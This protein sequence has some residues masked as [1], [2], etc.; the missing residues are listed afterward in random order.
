[1]SGDGRAH[2]YVRRGSDPAPVIDA[3]APDNVGRRQAHHHTSRQV[4]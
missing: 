3:L 4:D 2:R 1:M